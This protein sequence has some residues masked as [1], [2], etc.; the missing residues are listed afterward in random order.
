MLWI[1]LCGHL[2]FF[3]GAGQN[4]WIGDLS[5]CQSML[6]TL[7]FLVELIYLVGIFFWLKKLGLNSLHFVK[8]TES[9]CLVF[10]CVVGK[11]LVLVFEKSLYGISKYRLWGL[12][13]VP[14][15][16]SIVIAGLNAKLSTSPK[17]QYFKSTDFNVQSPSAH[18]HYNICGLSGIFFT[19]NVIFGL[20]LIAGL[21][22]VIGYMYITRMINTARAVHKNEELDLIQIHRNSADREVSRETMQMLVHVRKCGV[23]ALTSFCSTFL[24]MMIVGT[25]KIVM[26]LFI[27]SVFNGILILTSF[28]FADR[29]HNFLFGC[30]SQKTEELLSR[31]VRTST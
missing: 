17:C 9:F 1:A 21:N 6:T 19:I 24:A 30:C 4:W 20:A 27:D 22:I 29:I 5:P 11:I 25:C 2:L 7:T 10:F 31:I 13:L 8:Q 18:G 14:I 28:T 15:V 3:I 26:I 23:I 16:G 12:Y